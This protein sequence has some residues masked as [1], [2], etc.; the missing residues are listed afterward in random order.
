LGASFGKG[1]FMN[2]FLCFAL[3][4][5]LSFFVYAQNPEPQSLKALST[6]MKKDVLQ[7]L[8]EPGFHFNYKAPNGLHV[9]QD[10][11]S[12]VLKNPKRMDFRLQSKDM[13]DSYAEVYV[14]DD[15]VTF[16]ETHSIPLGTKSPPQRK[17]GSELK[18][19]SSEN[20]TQDENGFFRGNLE[21]ILA[22]ARKENR[23]VL[24]DFS[25]I[26][27]PGCLRLEQEIFPSKEFKD[28][29]KEYLLVKVDT[30]RFE[31]QSFAKKYNIKGIPSLLIAR[32]DG[33]EIQRIYDYQPLSV[34]RG[35]FESGRKNSTP[36]DELEK[37]YF[38]E[39]KK[40]DEQTLNVLAERYYFAGRYEEALRAWEKVK[41]PSHFLWDAKIERAKN[42]K[43]SVQVKSA[44]ETAIK[45]EP[46]SFRSLGWRKELIQENHP[47]AE[48]YYAEGLRL[49]NQFWG[50]KNIF[51]RAL[52]TTQVGDM[53]GFESLL[54]ALEEGDLRA[55]YLTQVK[56]KPEDSFETKEAWSISVKKT[57]DLF[58]R[59][60]PLGPSLRYL[61][62]LTQAQQFADAE[63]FLKSLI[64][65]FPQETDLNRRLLRILVMQKKFSEAV[66]IGEKALKSS[67]GR[68]EFW[69]IDFLAQ[70][71]IGHGTK[72]KAKKLLEKSLGR[73]EL[74]N[75]NM[76]KTKESLEKLKSSLD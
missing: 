6:R 28:W 37:K 16:C 30:D 8:L 65:R 39:S 56:K 53:T 55:T 35:F 15:E 51:D 14:C 48:T 19:V 5:I 34:F 44:L 21:E 52:E 3:S 31:N 1:G 22:R 42:T 73:S 13:A 46:S 38:L 68:N 61:S 70:A 45:A 2:L 71:Y 62:G 76:K 25:A 23:Q 4:F 64:E 74:K 63:K 47:Q 9:G 32:P 50:D 49:V 69:T 12:P 10:F 17:G 29:T 40:V 36:L 11:F 26:W 43:D 20:I 33:S 57:S 67:Y 27:C 60:Q 72:L 18:G 54:L 24:F 59:P 75:E 7:V 66:K 41:N 58:Q